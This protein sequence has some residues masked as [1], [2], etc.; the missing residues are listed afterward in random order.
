LLTTQYMDEADELADEIVVIDHGLVIAAGTAAE[1][2]GRVGGDVLEFAVSDRS[3]LDDA[4]AAVAA[5][6]AGEPHA[7]PDAATV[8]VTVGGWGSDALAEAV[9]RLDAARVQ[10]YGL[11][12]RMPSLDDVF[13]AL[14]GPPVQ[15]DDDGRS[16]RRGR[17]RPRAADR[18][19]HQ[20]GSDAMSAARGAS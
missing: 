1:L 7:D 16:R 10:T 15:E 13:L 8:R 9:R 18:P 17:R 14:T 20:D 3:R 19:R 5:I 6:S 2:K 11:T 12:V 4:I